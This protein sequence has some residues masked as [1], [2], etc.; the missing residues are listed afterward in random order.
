MRS[1]PGRKRDLSYRE[2]L[3]VALTWGER[4]NARKGPR[5]ALDREVAN[6]FGTTARMVRRCRSELRRF[7]P[8]P[9]R[10]ERDHEAKG[11]V[12]FEIR[13]LAERLMTPERLA[14]REP[15]SLAFGTLKVP[16]RVGFEWEINSGV[17]PSGCQV[18]LS[19][20]GAYAGYR[21]KGAASCL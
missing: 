16:E 8:H 15:L 4:R 14:K 17:R 19:G 5:L 2:R 9:V 13:Q 1:T 18:R 10:E 11:R 20:H 6:A 7:L 21:P 12:D 3:D